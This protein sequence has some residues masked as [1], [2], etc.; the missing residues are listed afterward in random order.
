MPHFLNVWP[1][2]SRRLRDARG[3]LL[4]L[5][6]DGT[7]A[8]IVDR[9]ELAL[10]PAE[11]RASLVHLSRREKYVVGIVSARSLEDVKARVGIDDLVYAGNHGLEISGPGLDF[12]HP[13][14][15]RLRGTVDQAYRQ[16]QQGLTHL[17]GVIIE[18]KGL[19]LTVHYR[20][21]PEDV[22]G[23][24][25]EAV[26]AAAGP[27]VESGTIIISGGK[28]AFE[29]RPG[30]AWDKG[31]AVGKLQTAFPQASLPVFFGDDLPDE[32][33]FTAVQEAGGMGVFVG[34]AR[35][36]TAALYRVDS[37]QEVAEALGLMVQG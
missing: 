27:F 14:A 7:L 3:V 31:K 20:L 13:E 29:V 28:K 34:P 1:T 17:A 9:P 30:L 11:A 12:V 19:T 35:Q 24:V 25:E 36:P 33:G 21:T 16:L 37:P 8:P 5:D 6:Y 22:V 15:T 32:E 18:H 23:E 26:N 2:V 4:M 10:L